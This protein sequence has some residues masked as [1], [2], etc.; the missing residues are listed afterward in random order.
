MS[1]VTP[2][3]HSDVTAILKRMATGDP[4]AANH[5]VP[6]IYRDLRRIADNYIRRERIGH[7]LQPTALVHEAYLRIVGMQN[8]TWQDRVH[9]V[10]V[11]ST[12]MRRILIDYARH[13]NVGVEGHL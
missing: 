1:S 8:V 10:A 12:L 11:A 13:R 2:D 6:L 9:F 5:L 7:T 3:P 4:E